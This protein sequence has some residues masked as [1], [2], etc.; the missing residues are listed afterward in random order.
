[1]WDVATAQTVK[2]FEGHSARVNAV[3]FNADASVV[4][5]GSYDRSVRFW[6]VKGG[7]RRAI[8]VLEEAT[9]AV[10]DVCVWGHEVLAGSVDGR[11]RTY[12][13]RMGR[14]LVDCVCPAGVTGVRVSRDGAA[15]LVGG[16]DGVVRLLDRATGGLL[17]AYKGHRSEGLRVRC[18]FAG[19]EKWV[20]SGSEE[21]GVWA[22]DLLSGQLAERL[23]VGGVVSCVEYAPGGRNQMACGGQDGGVVVWSE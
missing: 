7:N 2:R 9:D 13:M 6:D 14:V 22:W 17:M 10:Q 12:D 8:Q 4:V 5:S 20:V 19:A 3:A 18:G 1:M 16:L 21:G 11:V 15:M 23:E